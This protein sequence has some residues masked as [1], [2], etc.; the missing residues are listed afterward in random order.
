MTPADVID[1]LLYLPTLRLEAIELFIRL[2]RE[3]PTNVKEIVDIQPQ[4]ESAVE[5]LD[6]HVHKTEAMVKRCQNLRPLPSN[7]LPCGF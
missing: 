5:Q 1:R 2:Q 6:D 4:V 7:N 3:P